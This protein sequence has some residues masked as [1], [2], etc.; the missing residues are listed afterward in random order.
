VGGLEIW[1]KAAG[2]RVKCEGVWCGARAPQFGR[3]EEDDE[4]TMDDATRSSY[5]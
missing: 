1:N 3:R 5:D 4:D 2:E